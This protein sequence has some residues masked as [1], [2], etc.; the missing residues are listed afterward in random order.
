[1]SAAR[2]IGVVSCIL[3]IASF[4]LNWAWYPD[5]Q[6]YFTAFFSEKN[7]YGKP[8]I[9][10]LYF[11]VTGLISYLSNKI[12]RLMFLLYGIFCWLAALSQI[13]TSIKISIIS[14]VLGAI[15]YLLYRIWDIVANWVNLLFCALCMAFAIRTYLLYTSGYDGYVPEPQPGIYLM[16]LGCLGHLIASMT[17]MAVKKNPATGQQEI[18]G[19]MA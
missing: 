1:M 15:F 19:N 12:M 11:S 3:I 5:I 14:I 7:Y 9:V 13:S 17:S 4:F 8:G 16:L 10:L 6:K 18:T 2:I